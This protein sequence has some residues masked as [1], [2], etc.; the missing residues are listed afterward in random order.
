MSSVTTRPALRVRPG[1]VL[2]QML[3]ERRRTLAWWSVSIAA[4]AAIIGASYP[5]V[6]DFGS[7][8]EELLRQLP[9]GVI[10][11]MGAGGG[12]VSPEGYLNSR[13]YSGLFPILL[14]VFGIMVAAWTVAGAEREGT[15]E[16]LLANPV[17]RTRVA[18]ERFAGTA[19]LLAM[20]TFVGTAV[21]VVLR[22][23]FELTS[24]GVGRLV[25]AGVGVFLLAMVFT[26]LTF[27]TGAATGNKGAAIAA[28][29]GAAAATYLVFALAAFVEFFGNL[30]WLSPWDWFLSPSPLTDGWTAWA[31]WPPLLVI[32]VAVALGTALFARRDLR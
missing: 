18:L 31:V 10:E 12:L 3:A 4:L 15:L 17:S 20:L 23:P 8:L 28:G 1:I 22:G 27:A 7:Q 26:A 32:A 19:V 2:R 16:P 5:T 29:A 6:K 13:F 21:F 30:R 11:L 9:R 24:L 25:A 14:L